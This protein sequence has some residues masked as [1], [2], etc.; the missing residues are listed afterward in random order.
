MFSGFIFLF[1]G[2][3]LRFFMRRNAAGTFLDTCRIEEGPA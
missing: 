2:S 3:Y 1:F